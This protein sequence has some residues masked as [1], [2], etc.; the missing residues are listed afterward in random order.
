MTNHNRFW[1]IVFLFLSVGTGGFVLVYNFWLA[2]N[3]Y[4]AESYG[5]SWFY[6]I[7]VTDAIPILLM[8]LNMYFMFKIMLRVGRKNSN[9]AYYVIPIGVN[10]SMLHIFPMNPEIFIFE[11]FAGFVFYGGLWATIFL[12]LYYYWY[13]PNF[14]ERES[15]DQ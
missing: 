5:V 13:L 7:A 2:Y 3:G 15:L 11:G 14:F 1:S 6:L 8:S 12:I 10:V 9:A 4:V